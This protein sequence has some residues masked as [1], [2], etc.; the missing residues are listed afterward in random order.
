MEIPR[1]CWGGSGR[2]TVPAFGAGQE[3]PHPAVRRLTDS[4]LP[5]PLGEGSWFFPGAKKPPR[6]NAAPLGE[7]T[8][9]STPSPLESEKYVVA[10]RARKVAAV[11]PQKCLSFSEGRRW[12]RDDAG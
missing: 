3:T 12:L 11:P 6:T 2:L 4:G 5:S 10:S 1:L 9:L 7:G 8:C